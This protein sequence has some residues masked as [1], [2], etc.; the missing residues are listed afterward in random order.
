MLSAIRETKRSSSHRDVIVERKRNESIKPDWITAFIRR[1]GNADVFSAGSAARKY[2]GDQQIPTAIIILLAGSFLA[3]GKPSAGDQE[4][5]RRRADG[6]NRG[7]S[8]ILRSFPVAANLARARTRTLSGLSD[9]PLDRW[10]LRGKEEVEE[11]RARGR[12]ADGW[13]HFPAS[14]IVSRER[15]RARTSIQDRRGQLIDWS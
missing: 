14:G 12:R 5:F 4:S 2:G 6:K 7:R 10:R 1:R 8:I 11:A 3:P 15:A 13:I 9:C